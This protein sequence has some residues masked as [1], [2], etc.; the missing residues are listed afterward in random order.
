MIKKVGITGGIGSGKS[1]ICQVIEKMGFPV[2]YS[3]SESKKIIQT[4]PEIRLKLTALFGQEVFSNN[5]LNRTFLAE[6]IFKSDE[7]RLKVNAIIHPKVRAHFK[8]WVDTQSSHIVFNEAAILFET[9]AYKN[10]DHV[11]L[12]T[13]P[14]ETRIS[15][16]MQRDNIS[17]EEVEL[18]IS[19]QWSDEEK[20]GYTNLVIENDGRP[21]LSQ[22]E[23]IIEKIEGENL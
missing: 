1:F 11:I 20:K 14:E 21:I 3:D 15:R 10:F 9:G 17:I 19:K 7:N 23:A 6:Q 18:R 16:V 4:D 5:S 22:I 13:A 12:V 8:E 2:Y